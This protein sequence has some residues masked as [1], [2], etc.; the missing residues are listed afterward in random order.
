MDTNFSQNKPEEDD[1]GEAIPLFKQAFR[2]EHGDGVTKDESQAV[3]LYQQAVA[4][5]HKESMNNLALCYLEGR[6][7]EQDGPKAIQLLK[8]AADLGNI[9][10]IYNLV[11]CYHDGIGV[12]KD[13]SE[14]SLLLKSWEKKGLLG[15]YSRR[16]YPEKGI[17]LFCC[18]LQTIC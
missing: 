5:G 17:M 6:G 8:Q 7:V 10:A 13:Y 15:G 16:I 11:T 2:L 14:A 9:N 18:L 3:N 4:I 1:F 12:K